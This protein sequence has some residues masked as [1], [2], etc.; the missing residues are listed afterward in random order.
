MLAWVPLITGLLTAIVVRRR[1]FTSAH[2]DD[3]VRALLLAGALWGTYLTALTEILSLFSALRFGPLLVAWALPVPLLLWS[4]RRAGPTAG[5]RWPTFTAWESGVLAISALIVI[6]TGFVAL[7]SAPNTWDSMTYHLPRMMHWAQNG[8][9]AHYPTHEPRQ[10]YLG[11][12]TEVAATHFQILGGDDRGA[13]LLQWLAMTSSLLAVSTIAGQLGAGR[14]GRVLSVLTAAT[15]PVGLL[16]AVSTQTDYIVSFHLLAAACFLSD[17]KKH[18]LCLP[19]S[20]RR[21]RL[22]PSG[23]MLRLPPSWR[24]FRCPHLWGAALATGLAVLTKGTAYVVLAPFLA[25]FVWPLLRTKRPATWRALAVFAAVVLAINT[26]HYVRN[27]RLFDSPLQPSG[28][29]AYH[30]YGNETHGIAVTISNTARFA[31][32]HLT[33]PDPTLVRRGYGAVRDLH[34]PLGIEPEDPRTTWPGMRFEPPPTLVHEDFSGNFLHS[35]L[36]VVCCAAA[37]TRRVRRALPGLGLHVLL[38][39]VGFLLF[40]ALLKWTPWSTRLQLPLFLLAS[41]AIGTWLGSR[42][43]GRALVTATTLALMAQAVPFLIQN[44]LHKL[45]GPDSVFRLTTTQQMFRARPMLGEF[46]A[47]AAQ[48]VA[49]TECS[50]LGLDMPPDAWEYPLWLVLRQASSTSIRLENLNADNISRS[51]LDPRFEPCAVVC[52]SCNPSNRESYG[53]R[54][55]EPVMVSN[56]DLPNKHS[57]LLFLK[58]R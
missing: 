24:V 38:V 20:G 3:L 11:P 35:V 7:Y 8:S 15:I 41:P 52:L 50:N 9:V 45:T 23:G 57:H 34:R 51:L 56:D 16:Q 42:H 36:I 30:Q 6:V 58:P 21:F 17:A 32:L 25:A 27:S 18:L 43:P 14:G 40:A 4:L 10:L 53:A 28:L 5:I 19:P 33:I 1:V 49:A 47:R 37:C 26:G 39:I 54:F 48:R 22:P 31:A 46:Y 44:P 55:G 2:G 13:R 12:W 29:G